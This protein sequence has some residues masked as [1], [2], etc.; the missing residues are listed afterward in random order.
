M[1]QLWKAC[2]L[3]RRPA[4]SLKPRDSGPMGKVRRARSPSSTDSSAWSTA[5]SA[6]SASSAWARGVLAFHSSHTDGAR[7]SGVSRPARMSS[8]RG[9]A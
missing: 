2:S 6:A 5:S 7:S 4:N 1:S 3:R 9:G 8:Q